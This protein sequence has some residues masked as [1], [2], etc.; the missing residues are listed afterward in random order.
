MQYISQGKYSIAENS[1]R[2][3]S[4]YVN[5]KYFSNRGGTVLGKGLTI[6]AESKE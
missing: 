1:V 3:G 2:S 5:N 6:R 4:K